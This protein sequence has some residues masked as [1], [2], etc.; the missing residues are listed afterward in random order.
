[1]PPKLFQRAT[2]PGY[3]GEAETARERLERLELEYKVKQAKAKR[4]ARNSGPNL[5][6]KPPAIERLDPTQDAVWR[7]VVDAPVE[8]DD[9]DH[10]LAYVLNKNEP[11]INFTYCGQTPFFYA[12]NHGKTGVVKLLLRWPHPNELDVNQR[13][14][15]GETPFLAACRGDHLGVVK[16]LLDPAN[17]LCEDLDP[18][19]RANDGRS[20]LW[21]AA[22]RGHVRTLRWLLESQSVGRLDWETSADGLEG[23]EPPRKVSALQ[24]A[25]AMKRDEAMKVVKR[26]VAKQRKQRARDRMRRAQKTTKASVRMRDADGV[27]FGTDIYDSSNLDEA[28]RESHELGNKKGIDYSGRTAATDAA[29]KKGMGMFGGKKKSPFG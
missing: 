19:Q 18:N 10:E 21:C 16:V 20:P 24:A 22:H 25:K 7:A 17:R 1:M 27:F 14:D 12:C 2:A 5:R 28:G 11:E 13:S 4:R 26:G 9:D 3:A 8:N 15:G 29:N 23:F 6:W